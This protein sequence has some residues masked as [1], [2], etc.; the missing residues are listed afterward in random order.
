MPAEAPVLILDECA[1]VE[2]EVEVTPG[3]GWEV[4]SNECV[5][6]LEAAVLAEDVA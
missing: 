2:E 4:L 6:F 5:V 1:G 3:V